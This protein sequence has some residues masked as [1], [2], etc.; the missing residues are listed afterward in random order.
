MADI[1]ATVDFGG[2]T[3]G[4]YVATLGCPRIAQQLA[5]T[6]GSPVTAE[7]GDG[8]AGVLTVGGERYELR[9]RS[10]ASGAVHLE[11]AARAPPRPRERVPR[12]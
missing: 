2:A 5:Y 3:A 6:A 1:D 9:T 11:S 10:E 7:F 4:S 8:G 12:G